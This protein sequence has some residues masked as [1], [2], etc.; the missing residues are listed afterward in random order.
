MIKSNVNTKKT[1]NYYKSAM[2][3]CTKQ[4][5]LVNLGLPSGTLWA[6]RN[7]GADAPEQF[8]SYFRFGETTPFTL[9]PYPYEPCD[10]NLK[11]IIAGTDKD[12]ATSLIGDNYQMPTWK[13]I[14][15]LV[16]NCTWNWTE[17][18]HVK[19]VKVT[20]PNGNSIFFPAAGYLNND[21]GA[22]NAVGR[23]GYYW[24][25]EVNACAA[26]D[27][28]DD[29]GWCLSFSQDINNS[30]PH[31]GELDKNSDYM[32]REYPFPIRPVSK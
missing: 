11:E 32:T 12:A 31:L 3:P 5:E 27:Y 23:M 4:P 28:Y 10:F 9:S 19:G 8:G 25:A 24:S 15:E 17:Q 30:T 14:D 6:D 29:C 16:E 1:T 18:N 22:N 2:F 7:I 26:C 13:Q 21:N 20:G